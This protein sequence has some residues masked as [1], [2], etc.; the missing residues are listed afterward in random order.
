ML[1]RAVAL[2]Y[3]AIISYFRVIKVPTI[4]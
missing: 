2:L 4:D 3:Y 1:Q